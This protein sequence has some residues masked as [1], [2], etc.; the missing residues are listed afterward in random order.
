MKL[1]PGPRRR[2]RYVAGGI[3]GEFFPDTAPDGAGMIC[4]VARARSERPRWRDRGQRA[5]ARSSPGRRSQTANYYDPLIRTK[6]M[7]KSNFE[8]VLYVLVFFGEDGSRTDGAEEVY[9]V[10]FLEMDGL[11]F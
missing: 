1:Q 4:E 3:A 11:G 9:W 5:Y 2:N 6:E 7:E 8:A 10:R